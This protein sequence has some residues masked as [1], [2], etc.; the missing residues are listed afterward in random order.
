LR[1][2]ERAGDALRLLAS[3][4]AGECPDLVILD[5]KLPDASGYDVLKSIRSSA[6]THTVPVVVMSSSSDREDIDKAYEYRAN[7]FITKLTISSV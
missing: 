4:T 3:C 2:S 1:V 5:L 7:C 6:S